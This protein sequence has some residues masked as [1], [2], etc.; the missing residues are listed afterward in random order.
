MGQPRDESSIMSGD[1]SRVRR[2]PVGGPYAYRCPLCRTTSLPVETKAAAQAEGHVHRRKFHG[3]HRP[4]GEEIIRVQYAPKGWSDMETWE[5]VA[6]VA[7]VLALL[8]GVWV[9]F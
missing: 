5:K 2:A 1:E 9:K 6:S 4:D 8:I 3:G 7:I